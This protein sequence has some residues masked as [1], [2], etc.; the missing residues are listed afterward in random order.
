MLCLKNL[1]LLQPVEAQRGKGI[2]EEQYQSWYSQS[3]NIRYAL[4]WM[5]SQYGG[6]YEE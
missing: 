3:E 4:Q 6:E 5:M 2:S 1:I